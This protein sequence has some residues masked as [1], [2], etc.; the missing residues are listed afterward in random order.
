MYSYGFGNSFGNHYSNGFDD[1][2]LY[3]SRAA[4]SGAESAAVGF[5]LLFVVVFYAVLLAYVLVNYIMRA[6]GLYRIAKK[7]GCAN[8]WL[9]W[10]P[11]G[12]LFLLGKVTGDVQLGKWTLKNTKLWLLLVPLVGGLICGGIYVGMIIALV[13]GIGVS[14]AIGS[15]ASAAPILIFMLMFFV[16]FVAVLAVSLFFSVIYGMTYYTLCRKYKESAHSVF[17]TLMA[18]FVPLADAIL[19]LRMSK[20]EPLAAPV[21]ANPYADGTT[22]NT[23]YMGE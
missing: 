23:M 1:S 19:M 5:M 9:A 16:F 12:D 10:I 8:A 11:F 6:I 21:P 20:M 18:I 22:D 4:M 3:G 14:A 2:M 13:I 17:Y 15:T 7:S